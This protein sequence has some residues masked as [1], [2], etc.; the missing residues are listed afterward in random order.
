MENAQKDYDIYLQRYCKS[1][2]ISAEE[3]EK[4]KLVRDVKDY[5]F[6]DS[7]VDINPF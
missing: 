6:N 4:H 3:A 2:R 1:Y 7:H 5:Y